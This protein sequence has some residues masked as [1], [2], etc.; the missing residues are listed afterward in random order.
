[1]EHPAFDHVINDGYH[2]LDIV[3]QQLPVSKVERGKFRFTCL[4]I[5]AVKDGIEV[6][7][8][9][10][11]NSLKGIKDIRKADVDKEE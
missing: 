4:D 10:Y 11:I 5:T 6:E 7:I 8:D 3:D 1:M 2:V 9:N